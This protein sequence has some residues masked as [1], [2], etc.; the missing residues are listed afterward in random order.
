MLVPD[1]NL[2]YVLQS[3]GTGGSGREDFQKYNYPIQMWVV[4]CKII[5][6]FHDPWMLIQCPGLKFA[7]FAWRDWFAPDMF[8]L[9]NPIIYSIY[10]LRIVK[11]IALDIDTIFKNNFDH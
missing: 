11:E 10:F 9:K 7:R 4:N 6:S 3:E 8:P 5:K 2:T 1:N